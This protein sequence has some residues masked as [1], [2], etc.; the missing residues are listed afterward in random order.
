MADEPP[1]AVVALVKLLQAATRPTN[2][3]C[4]PMGFLDPLKSKLGLAAPLTRTLVTFRVIG[5]GGLM[6]RLAASH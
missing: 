3:D 1:T 4:A 2:A 5:P 6:P